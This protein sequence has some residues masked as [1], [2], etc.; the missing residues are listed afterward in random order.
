M[1]K[2]LYF[3]FWLVVYLGIC[4]L[5][6]VIFEDK[7]TGTYFETAIRAITFLIAVVFVNISEK[8]G[9]NSWSKVIGF[10]R[11]KK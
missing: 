4:L 9:W 10:F 1:S 7:F 11:H 6:D 3:L 5:C 8:K 2:I